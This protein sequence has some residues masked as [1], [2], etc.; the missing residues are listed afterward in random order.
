MTYNRSNAEE[1]VEEICAENNRL[2][3]SGPYAIPIARDSDPR[4]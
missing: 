2:P 3:T 4:F 1:L